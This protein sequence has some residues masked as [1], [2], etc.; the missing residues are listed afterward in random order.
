MKKYIFSENNFEKK[1]VNID[2]SLNPRKYK[3]PQSPYGQPMVDANE[4]EIV[5]W[6]KRLM[7]ESYNSKL[8]YHF[9]WYNQL[10][11]YCSLGTVQNDVKLGHDPASP[12]VNVEDTVFRPPLL[13]RSVDSTAD[14]LIHQIMKPTRW[15]D[16]SNYDLS[17]VKLTEAQRVYV[18]KMLQDAQRYNAKQRGKEAFTDLALFGN[19]II[20]CDFEQ[21]RMLTEEMEIT[22]DELDLEDPTAKPFYTLKNPIIVDEILDQYGCFK[23]IF[24]GNYFCDP[25]PKNGDKKNVEYAGHFEYMSNEELWDTF[26][27]IPKIRTRLEST[28]RKTENAAYMDNFVKSQFTN[29]FNGL[30]HNTTSR[31][32]TRQTNKITYLE[33]RKT[34]TCI[35]NDEIVVYHKIRD[36]KLKRKGWNSYIHLSIPSTT[37]GLWGVGYGWTLRQLQQEQNMLASMRLQF[38][39]VFYKPFFEVTAES[40]VDAIDIQSMPKFNVL[41]SKVPGQ[42]QFRT[43]P[44]GSDTIFQ[45]A[46]QANINRTRYYAAQPDIFDGSADKTHQTG[47][48]QKMEAAQVPFNNLLAQIRDDFNVLFG[49]IHETNLALLQGGVDVHVSD[50]IDD[51][52][53]SA[54]TLTEEHLQILRENRNV[55]QIFAG[56]DLSEDKMN[57]LNQLLQLPLIS[58]LLQPVTPGTKA[59]IGGELFAYASVPEIDALIKKDLRDQK[60]AQEQAMAA[61]PMEQMLQ[62]PETGLP[63]QDLNTP[64]P[65]PGAPPKAQQMPPIPQGMPPQG[66]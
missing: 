22:V 53:T 31:L 46:E 6:A 47:M 16:F 24:L 18:R 11:T 32:P 55:M 48:A 26:G 13:K 28:N 21:E 35:I 29:N 60:K 9:L 30:S 4:E 37:G 12:S 52:E 56:K 62:N 41:R 39:D 61:A 44:A 59:I 15:L 25:N 40:G 65:Q 34:E 23:N 10:L 50:I 17:N 63:P 7:E 20:K 5:D 1:V 36:A 19:A 42:L 8:N 27:S 49:K 57:S 64:S 14:W 54:S 45:N 43:P 51:P 38:L 58:E 33:T 66:M 3:N 2:V